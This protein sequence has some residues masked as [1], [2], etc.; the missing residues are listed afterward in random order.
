MYGEIIVD[1]ALV[2]YSI[3]DHSLLKQ[4]KRRQKDY[5]TALLKLGKSK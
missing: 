1:H 5:V 4:T 2:L 3:V